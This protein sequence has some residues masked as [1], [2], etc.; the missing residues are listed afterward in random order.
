M[1][2][3]LIAEF[4]GPAA[5]LVAVREVKEM[6]CE[7]VDVFSPF[8]IEGLAEMLGAVST[9]L[10]VYMFVGGA[11]FAA[12]AYGIEVW[13]AIFDYPINSGGRPLNSWPTFVQFPFAVGILGAALT[14]FA[15]LLAQ[16]GLPR[17][18]H[19]LFSINGFERAT[20]DGFLLAVR[21]PDDDTNEARNR[22]W[23]AGASNIW[24]AET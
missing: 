9:R 18:R 15:G 2:R 4:E 1:T 20:Q 7:L 21:T 13:S 12:A 5:L 14:G 24:D 16:T 3:T 19:P 23:H 22:L 6:R 11:A 8:P 10:R 17:L